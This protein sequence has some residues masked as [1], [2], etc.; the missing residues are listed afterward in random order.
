[1]M[2]DVTSGIDG[3]VMS[4]ESN[5]VGRPAL[6]GDPTGQGA[7]LPKLSDI[8]ATEAVAF[9]RKLC[10]SFVYS[11]YEMKKEHFSTTRSGSSCGKKYKASMQKSITEVHFLPLQK[12]S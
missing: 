11:K 10:R 8:M 4:E 5:T 7:L 2:E 9:R 3:V 1:M 6:G 12:H